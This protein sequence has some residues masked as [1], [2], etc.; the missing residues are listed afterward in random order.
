ML[1][2]DLSASLPG[3][4]LKGFK[5]EVRVRVKMSGTA[6]KM[7]ERKVHGWL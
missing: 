5:L 4:G 2:T 1:Q 7:S 3:P 6:S